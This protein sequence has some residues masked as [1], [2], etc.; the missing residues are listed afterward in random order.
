MGKKIGWGNKEIGGAKEP[1]LPR[2]LRE[3]VSEP[4]PDPL[5]GWEEPEVDP[6]ASCPVCRSF[7]E[8][9]CEESDRDFVKRTRFENDAKKV[10]RCSICERPLSVVYVR[11][12]GPQAS[13][14]YRLSQFDAIYGCSGC[15][16]PGL[17]TVLI[18]QAER[19]R[20]R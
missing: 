13:P 15:A 8:C 4:D 7:E 5:P 18:Q 19:E 12:P 3:K 16:G 1:R 9:E 2:K 10:A 6:A 20:T 11:R 17:A 14:P